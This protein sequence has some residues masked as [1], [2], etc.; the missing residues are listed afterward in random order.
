MVCK[1]SFKLFEAQ[2]CNSRCRDVLGPLDYDNEIEN[3]TFLG[4]TA[5]RLST[6]IQNSALRCDCKTLDA[7]SQLS[8]PV[9]HVSRFR[10]SIALGTWVARRSGCCGRGTDTFAVVAASGAAGGA[11]TG[12]CGL[13]ESERAARQRSRGR[14]S[15]MRTLVGH[16]VTGRGF[17]VGGVT[18]SV[19]G[20]GDCLWEA[21]DLR[22]R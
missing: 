7:E 9:T 4:S 3:L 6:K 21:C 18:V 13:I 11:V 14:L 10:S 2:S 1:G 19:G 20:G 22:R 5:Y 16:L 8:M 15:C 17:G 12:R